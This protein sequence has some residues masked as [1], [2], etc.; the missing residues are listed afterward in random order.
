MVSRDEIYRAAL[1]LLRL[2]V[3]YRLDTVH[4]AKGNL[5]NGANLYLPSHHQYSMNG[6]YTSRTNQKQIIFYSTYTDSCE[7]V[8]IYL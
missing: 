3:T 2:Q 5:S 4:L 6:T 7:S 8:N 1:N